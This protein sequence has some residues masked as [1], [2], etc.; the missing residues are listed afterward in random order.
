[1][2]YKISICLTCATLALSACAHRQNKPSG[3]PSVAVVAEEI[4]DAKAVVRAAVVNANRIGD[5][6]S[7]AHTKAERI[8][9][10]AAVILE[11]WR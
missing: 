7:A 5:R 2:I 6:V 10:K 8:E 11:N 1:M 4:S 9:G 3:V